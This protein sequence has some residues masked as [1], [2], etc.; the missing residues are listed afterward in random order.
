ML[1]RRPSS[2]A[3]AA[4]VLAIDGQARRSPPVTE[5]HPLN[6]L[7]CP[8]NRTPLRKAGTGLL[9]R[10]NAAILAGT[11]RNRSGR[12]I[13]DPLQGGW[14]RE[15][16]SLLYPSVDEIPLLLVDEAIPLSG[17]VSKR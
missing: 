11:V 8:E 16:N 6:L 4:E 2:R 15:D 12:L 10:L 7:V 9:A 17:A 5:K 14:L 13:Q 3:P 1:K